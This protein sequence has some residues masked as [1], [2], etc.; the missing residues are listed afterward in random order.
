MELITQMRRLQLLRWSYH[1]GV[2][3]CLL[4]VSGDAC[5]EGIAVLKVG[6]EVRLRVAKTVKS[7]EA[8]Y[9]S[10]KAMFC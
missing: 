9:S 6:V 7:S 10:Y 8:S 1:V 5:H 3:C 2:N 4:N